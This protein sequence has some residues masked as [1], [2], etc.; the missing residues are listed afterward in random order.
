MKSKR[1]YVVL[2]DTNFLMIPLYRRVNV[3]DT[4]ED[5]LGLKPRYI[6]LSSSLREL[7]KIYSR[8]PVSKEGKA[9]QLGLRL[10]KECNIKVVEDTEIPGDTVDEKIIEYAK[11]VVDESMIRLIVA[12]NDRELKKRLRIL[13]IP[14]IVYRER[15][16]RV[17]L[18][19]EV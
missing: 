4:I 19:G 12:T 11:R 6:I 18:E 7:E 16:H 9:A 1:H 8:K 2:V 17:W 13:G 10:V 3:F 5:L 14:V 15:D